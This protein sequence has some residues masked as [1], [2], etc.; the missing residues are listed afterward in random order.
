MSDQSPALEY[1]LGTYFHQDFR[2]E[3]GGV[4]Q[5]VEAFLAE[6]PDDATALPG[7]IDAVLGA[8]PDADLPRLFAEFGSD[9]APTAEIGGHRGFLVELARRAGRQSVTRGT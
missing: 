1:L 9:F 5:T 6:N 8:L 3:H 2:L 7:E 4:W